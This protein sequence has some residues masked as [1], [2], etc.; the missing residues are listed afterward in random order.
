ME[1][2]LISKVIERYISVEI[3]HNAAQTCNGDGLVLKIKLLG[4][5]FHEVIILPSSKPLLP[6]QV[7]G[8]NVAYA[9]ICH[10]L[11]TSLKNYIE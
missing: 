10:L 6:N 2:Y 1:M 3:Q 9:I 5:S 8:V 4:F 7:R 11:Y